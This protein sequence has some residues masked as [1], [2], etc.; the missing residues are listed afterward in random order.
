[1]GENIDFGWKERLLFI[2]VI[3][4]YLINEWHR[5]SPVPLKHSFLMQQS[6]TPLWCCVLVLDRRFD[7][8][9]TYKTYIMSHIHLFVAF[10]ATLLPNIQSLTYEDVNFLDRQV[11]FENSANDLF[12]NRLN[13]KNNFVCTLEWDC[14]T[15]LRLGIEASHF[16]ITKIYHIM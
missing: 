3:G 4:S 8:L 1:M 7:R 12:T 10:C 13:G 16:A 11:Y 9:V 2:K 14:I 5:Y 6:V 15:C